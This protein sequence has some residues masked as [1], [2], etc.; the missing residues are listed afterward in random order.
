MYDI[1]VHKYI[2]NKRLENAAV[3]LSQKH[4]NISEAAS[5]SGYSNMSHFSAS[6]R[7]K[8]GVLPKDFCN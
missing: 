6:F 1:P 5:L 2:I 3:L 8:Y 7:K 4:I